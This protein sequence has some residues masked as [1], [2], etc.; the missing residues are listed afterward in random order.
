MLARALARRREMGI[1]L[2]VGASRLR[3]ARQLFVENVVLATLGGI[4]GLVLGRWALSLLLASAGDQV[5]AWASFGLDGRVVAFSVALSAA[6]ALLFG[7]APALHAIRGNLRGAM[8][9]T[10]AVTSGGPGGR[11]TLS[12]LVAAEFALAAVL[13]VCGGLLLRAYERVQKVDPGFRMDHVLTFAV[14]LPEASYGDDDDKRV[15]AFWDR[16]IQRLS[17]TPGATS[18]GLVSCPPLSCHW[19]M[20]YDIEGRAP[21]APGQANPVTLYRP[22]S[23]GYFQTMGIRLKSGRFFNDADGRNGNRVI[24]VNETFVKT[25]WPAVADPVGR[26]IR[27][28]GPKSPWMTVVGMV[29]DVKHYG[30]ERPMRPGV[31]VPLVQRPSSTMSVVIRTP[32]DP[33]AFTP[34]ARALVREMDPDLALYRVQTMEEALRKSLAQR[35]LYSWLL[36]VFAGMALVLA[37]GGTYGVTSYLVSQ[38]TRELGI[39]VALGARRQ[40]IIAT[41][42]RGG[43]VVVSAGV[44]LGVAASLGATRLLAEQLFGVQAYD[45]RVLS[46]A[47]AILVTTALVANW[48]PARRAARIDPMRSLRAE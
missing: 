23:P 13:L 5:P 27:G 17:A 44:V 30:L 33:A 35:A 6:T 1:R 8:S 39:R 25:F 28:N 47:I 41:V 37:L 2:A 3:L 9:G 21:L 22:A 20:F 14:A 48:L 12:A 10:S 16:L 11:R 7:W 42:M 15:M 4:A 26:R 19:G 32:G 18:V 24:I 31:Y 46:I 43:L 45:A 40:D 34:T 36:A 38:R 29:G